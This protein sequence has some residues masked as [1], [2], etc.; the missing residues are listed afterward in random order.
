MADAVLRACERE[1]EKREQAREREAEQRARRQAKHPWETKADAA[2][3][4]A[5]AARKASSKIA[6]DAR[7]RVDALRQNAIGV[8]GAA[9]ARPVSYTHLTLPTIPLV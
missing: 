8:D 7:A 6:N 1:D 3:R 9:G 5:F 2:H 4:V